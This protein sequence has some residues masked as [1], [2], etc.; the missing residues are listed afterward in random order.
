M[1]PDRIAQLLRWLDIDATSGRETLY[2]QT[3]EADLRREG[4]HTE[5][6]EVP[7]E[8]PGAR[9]NLLA[10]SG[11]APEVILCTHVDTVPPF[12][13]VD[14]REGAVWG[15]GACDTKGVLLAMIEA[16]CRLRIDRPEAAERVG[17]LLVVGEETDHCGAKAAEAMAMRPDRIIL[18]EPTCGRVAVGQKGILKIALEAQGIAGHSAFPDAGRSAI[19][20]LLD[21]LEALRCAPWPEDPQLGPTTLNVGF[22][23]GGVA[24]NVFAPSARAEI[25]IRAVADTGALLD[26]AQR[27]CARSTLKVLSRAE[28]QRFEPPEG[29]ETCV[30]PF[31][32]DAAWLRAL[33]PVWL[34]GPG[35]IRLAHS[36]HER[37][38]LHDLDSG[39][40]LYLRLILAAL[41]KD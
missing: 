23:E 5:R 2:L 33:G 6:L 21:D 9:W 7:G 30:V 3:L 38:D 20:D 41:D 22:I 28:P 31:N 24:S 35:D 14:A 36:V 27:A 32:S 34:A 19:H 13:P 8:D 4:L 16:L 17:I 11:R 10:T 26:L 15:R 1:T 29:F 37:I 25:M 40:D 12:L 18:G 39:A